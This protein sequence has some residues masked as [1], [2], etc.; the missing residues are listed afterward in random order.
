[1]KKLNIKQI[2]TTL[3]TCTTIPED[4]E[5]DCI[6]HDSRECELHA[7]KNILFF[8]IP[9]E[10]VNGHDFVQHA[11]SN[12]ASF[13]V[14]DHIPKNVSD[15]SKLI[16]VDDTIRA[17]DML[18]EYYL[19]QF[20]IIKIAVTGSVGK[21]ITKECIANVLSQKYKVH[22]SKG[23]FNTIIGL[24]ITI[25]DIE[26]EHEITILELGTN[27]F[28]EIKT[29]TKIVKPDIAII[30]NIGASHLEFLHDLKGVFKEKNDIFMQS[31]DKT[32]KIFNDTIT[33]LDSNKGKEHYY[34]YGFEKNNDY[35]V[36]SITIEN[37]AF[38]FLV[39]EEKFHIH[40]DVY[41]NVMN[42]IPAI[43]IGKNFG[44]NK[45]L[46]QKGLSITPEVNL[47]MEKKV[48]TRRNWT[49]IADCYNAN[50]MSMISALEYLQNLPHIYKIAILGNMLELGEFSKKYHEDI[51][52][53]V[54]EMNLYRSIAI[55]DHAENYNFLSHYKSAEDF[56]SHFSDSKFPDNSAIL[57]KA[58][59]GIAL[60]KIVE[61]L[62][63]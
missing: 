60:E 59:R 32:L 42:A 48:N 63:T 44:L 40:N 7:D 36:S 38:S 19:T 39:N 22:R 6:V 57:V 14:V 28:G 24:P 43:I 12:G 26:D 61:R 47:R 37:K 33:F 31:S 23:N 25:F 53:L 45:N 18:G 10:H 4:V 9:G 52:I 1:M 8:A 54:N 13:A 17:L 20:D 50:P 3:N 51:G 5:I 27:H 11:L 55:G 35:I 41:H 58:S 56:I 15:C 62:V 49:I 2:S 30:T 21:T 34:S 29:L 46:I 16:I